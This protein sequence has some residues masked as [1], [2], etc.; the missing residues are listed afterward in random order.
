MQ[1]ATELCRIAS[2]GF[3]PDEQKMLDLRETD[4]LFEHFEVNR[5][6]FWPIISRL[7]GGSIVLHAVL[8]ACIIFIPAVRDAL[9]VA[10]MFRGAGFVD[11]PYTKTQIENEGDIVE[12]SMERFRYPD[13]YF[14]IDAQPVPSP[15]PPIA[16]R[17]KSFPPAQLATPSPAATPSPIAS[18]STA[19]AATATP[20][21]SAEDDKAKQKVEAELDRAA[22]ENGVKRPKEINTRPFK[23]LLADAKKKKDSGEID[24][25]K[26]VEITIEA[27]RDLDGKL[28][29]AH[30][31]GG[32]KKLEA[33]A[34]D[35][36]SAL[37]DSGVLDFLEGTKHIKL[38]V[39]ID[40]KTVEVSASSEVESEERA[41]QMEKGYS[42][43]IVGGRII[44]RGQDEEIYYNHTEVTSKDKE[45]SVKFSMPRKEMGE[46][47]SK[48]AAK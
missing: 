12:I 30:V 33:V 26:Q 43:L 36:V 32:D 17:P 9:S 20:S 16:F 14:A 42:L 46:L 34:L 22:A 11:R 1:F 48:A 8:A 23:D 35:F 39:K 24:L 7:L 2:N 18:P 31:G 28:K 13:G 44:K 10:V 29:N 27:D 3:A 6:P 5:E 21:V 19:I 15:L 40:D 38:T 4:G 45:V 37:S 41:R 47:L 25:S